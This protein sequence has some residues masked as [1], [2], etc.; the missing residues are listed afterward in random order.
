[1]R[2]SLPIDEFVVVDIER[3]GRTW[4]TVEHMFD[5][6]VSDIRFPIDIV[7][8]WV[9]G[10]AVE[11]QRARQAAQA[12]A[13]LGEGDDAPRPLPADRR[14]QVRAPFRA[15]LRAV[16]PTDLHRDRL[17][18]AG[19]ARRPPE[20]PHRPER[21]VLA[22][23]SVLPT[24][25]SQAVES[26]LHHIRASAHSSTRTTTHV[27]RAIGRPVRV[28]Q[29]GVRDE[30][31]PR[32]DPDRPRL[33]QP[34]AQ[35]V[36]ELRPRQPA[37]PAAAVSAPSPPGTSNTPPTPLRASI[38]TEMEHEFADEFRATAA[39]RFRA[40]DNIS[41]TNSLYHYYALLTGRAIVQENAP[42]R[43]I[44]TTMQSGS[45]RS[46][47]AEEAKRR[48]LLP[49]R[50]QLPRGLGRGAYGARDGL[51]REVL[52]VPRP[53]G[54]SR[55]VRAPAPG[56]SVRGGAL[57]VLVARRAAHVRQRRHVVRPERT[58][59]A[60]RATGTRSSTVQDVA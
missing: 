54:A 2:R 7:F 58:H 44:D 8:S 13:V 51:P 12:N 30:V 5:D 33:E 55:R 59:A 20:G 36:R 19:L 39:S 14:A 6:H 24:H 1:M 17:A 23:P 16:D 60:R 27:L 46:T 56:P 22:D 9:D 52:P 3:Y 15:H 38:M 41:V 40:A 21:G 50:R 43:Y 10:N 35:R 37:S 57:P 42:V 25:N 31:H 28:L 48:L 53:L 45:A 47:T 26:Q 4:R 18:R 11:Y 49:E 34:G 29:P 32:D